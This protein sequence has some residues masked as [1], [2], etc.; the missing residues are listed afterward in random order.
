MFTSGDDTTD[1]VGHAAP[2][3]GLDTLIVQNNFSVD[4]W[5]V[6]KDTDSVCERL[7]LERKDFESL[8]SLAPGLIND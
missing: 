8:Q 4:L 5:Y 7:F 6:A 3:H 1:K 2:D